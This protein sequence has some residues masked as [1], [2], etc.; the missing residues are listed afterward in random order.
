MPEEDG[1]SLMRR[2][3]AANNRILAVALTGFASSQ[4]AAAAREAGFDVHVPKPLDID[5][6]VSLLRNLSGPRPA[7]SVSD[8]P[9]H[10][11]A[12]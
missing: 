3:R 9:V 10:A 6:L 8:G 2:L 4:D 1:Y 7:A 11:A 12:T 5:S